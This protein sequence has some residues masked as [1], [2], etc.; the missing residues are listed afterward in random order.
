MKIQF[1][2]DPPEDRMRLRMS[3]DDGKSRSVSLTRTQWMAVIMRMRAVM[4]REGVAAAEAPAAAPTVRPRRPAAELL[5]EA[6]P[7]ASAMR[8]GVADG[9]LRLTL[10]ADGKACNVSWPLDKLAEAHRSF[11]AR[12]EQVGWDVDAAAERLNALRAARAAVNKA[13]GPG[14]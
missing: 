10:E 8:M 9:R 4:Q 7:R 13:S 5:Q 2:Y 3:E 12:A 11:V 1:V 6:A 14:A